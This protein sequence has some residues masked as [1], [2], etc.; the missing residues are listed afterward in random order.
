[1]EMK[2]FYIFFLNFDFLSIFPCLGEEKNSKASFPFEVFPGEVSELINYVA[3][4]TFNTIKVLIY[5]N[6]STRCLNNLYHKLILI[7]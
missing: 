4:N 3:K 7:G 1:M 5:S 2:E 6:K